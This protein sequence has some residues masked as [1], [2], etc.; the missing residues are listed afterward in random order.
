MQ[1]P[2]KGTE[3]STVRL[4]T[5]SGPTTAVSAAKSAH[6]G[7]EASTA[8]DVVPSTAVWAT[9]LKARTGN[10]FGPGAKVRRVA[11]ISS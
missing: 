7:D 8:T 9:S 10:A 3:A 6:A 5:A 2:C 11:T 1:A 4:F